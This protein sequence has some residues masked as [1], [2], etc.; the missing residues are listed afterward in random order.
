MRSG[1]SLIE[2]VVAA[3]LLSIATLIALGALPSL[4]MTSQ[5]ARSRVQAL[6]IAQSLIDQE[7]SHP[8][9]LVPYLPFKAPQK[10]QKMEGTSTEFEPVVELQSV[11][12]YDPQHL[13]RLVVTVQWKERQQIY[14]VQQETM[15]SNVPRF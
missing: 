14:R 12:G 15:V 3:T 6:Q 7:R 10:A 8:W 5:R 11:S 9:R 4:V 13:R 2:T 1:I